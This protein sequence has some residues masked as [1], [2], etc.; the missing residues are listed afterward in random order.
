MASATVAAPASASP[1]LALLRR[2][3]GDAR[4]RTLSFLALFFLYAWMQAVGYR[5]AYPT[6]AARLDF[7]RS[8]AGND[9]LRLFY[10]YPYNPV[11]VGGYCAWRVGGVLAI[12]AGAYGLLGAVR[13]LRAEEEAGRL[14][15]VLAGT[16]GRQRAYLAS[17]GAV[18]AGIVLLWL[19]ETLGLLAGGL[20]LGGSA[21]LALATVSVAAVFAGVGAL[22]S[23]LAPTRRLALEISSGVLVLCLLL[24][25]IA[26]ASHS[27]DWLRWATPLGWAEQLRPFTGQQ[28][29]ALVALAAC[30]A[31]LV[32]IAGRLARSRDLGS[33]LLP[34]RDT[35]APR[36]RL[37][38]STLAHAVREERTSLAIWV[39]GAGGYGLVLGLVSSSISSAG[40]SPAMRRELK[41]LGS[42]SI[43]TPRGYLSLIFIFFVLT[44][45]LFACAQVAAAHREE[46]EQRLDTLLSLPV[47][48]S[49]WLAE[50][51]ALACGGAVL[52]ALASGA[53]TWLGAAWEGVPVTLM[54]MLEAGANCLP[55]GLLF[56]GL[57]ALA[58]ALLPR[59]SGALAYGLVT[60]AFLWELLGSVVRAPSWLL[61]LTPFAHI[62][63]V[64]ERPFQ[65]GAALVMLGGGLA[66]AL[67][68][69]VL[70]RRRDIGG[71]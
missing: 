29:A 67:A 33:G 45:S 5:D 52:I 1:G 57:A 18:G 3:F 12:V 8:F 17:L 65:L 68:A 9:A 16:I 63:F 25:A 22:V 47:G 32:A 21:Y 70:L 28:P 50:R 51:L 35:A 30:S 59:A 66:G 14:E 46:S 11:D 42:G 43:T 24:R 31:V 69:V 15:L 2:A 62:G 37:L 48:R 60:V 27:L 58:Y 44:V 56:L 7:A 6:L 34:A 41:L 49:R 19:A 4:T 36:T 39:L 55:A 54:Q 23:Q 61:K 53:M 10:G 40:I 38:G 20:P 26:D 71:G 13:A 64:P